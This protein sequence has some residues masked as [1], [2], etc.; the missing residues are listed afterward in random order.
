[1]SWLL[2]QG[3]VPSRRASASLQ[4]NSKDAFRNAFRKDKEDKQLRKGA[5]GGQTVMCQVQSPNYSSLEP[6][7]VEKHPEHKRIKM[8]Y[9]AIEHVREKIHLLMWVQFHT[10]EG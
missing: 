9:T 1:M 2:T 5:G 6:T 7:K 8:G 4:S 3:Q 10:T